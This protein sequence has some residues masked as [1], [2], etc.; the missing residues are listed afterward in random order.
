MTIC[1]VDGCGNKQRTRGYC[2]RHY[3]HILRYGF[4]KR[5]RKEPN[6]IILYEDK[7]EIILYNM[8]GEEVARA[9]IDVDDVDKVRDIKWGYEKDGRV[10]GF[11]VIDGK[12]KLVKLHRY[13]MQVPGEID[14]INRNQL[15]N[16]KGNLREVTSSHNKMNR[17][18]QANNTVG[19]KG[20]T[21][22]R[23]KNSVKYMAQIGVASEH[24][25]LG[26]YDSKIEAALAYNKAAKKYHGEFAC[27][28]TFEQSE[29][30]E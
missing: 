28:N 24:K 8:M 7:A 19:Y 9:I 5:S 20:V 27:L 6:E 21:A 29:N 22:I 23:T 3:K 18:K 1:I 15:D 16:R 26:V 17:G 11:C 10:R 14:H 4:V 12:R 30:M 25:Y 13:I 2:N